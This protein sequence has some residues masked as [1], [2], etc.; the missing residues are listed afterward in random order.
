LQGNWP[1][2]QRFFVETWI[3]ENFINFL[4]EFHTFNVDVD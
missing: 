3:G 4:V 2:P 1:K